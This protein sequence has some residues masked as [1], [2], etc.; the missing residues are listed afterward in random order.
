MTNTSQLSRYHN[1]G[2]NVNVELIK[3]TTVGD[4]KQNLTEMRLSFDLT[5]VETRNKHFA[6]NMGLSYRNLYDGE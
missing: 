4:P 5:G 2:D 3:V 6:S 1:S